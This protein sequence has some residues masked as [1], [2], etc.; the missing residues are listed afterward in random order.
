MPKVSI[1]LPVYNG[2]KTLAASLKSIANQTYRDFETLIVDNN[3]TDS[4]CDIAR[5]FTDTANVRIVHCKEQGLVPALNYG[6]YNSD[7][8]FM[9]RQDDDD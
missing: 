6:I 4:S 8:E 9:A 7:C 2:E 5:E 1:I 3:S